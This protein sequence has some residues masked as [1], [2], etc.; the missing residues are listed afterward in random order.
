MFGPPLK[1]DV[2]G[3]RD[4]YL[5]SASRAEGHANF[6][7][8]DFLEPFDIMLADLV[9]RGELTAFGQ[10]LAR[11][12][13][14][15]AL[16]MRLK[17][18][19]GGAAANTLK[20]PVFI[21]GLPRT[22]TT[23]LHEL[24]S[25]HPDLRA[26]TFHESH[27]YPH[28]GW[29]DEPAKAITHVQLFCVDTLAPTF[30]RVHELKAHGPHECVSIQGYAFRSM[31]FHVAFRLPLYNQFM[32]SDFDWAPAYKL[33]NQYLS[34]LSNPGDR[35]IL[36]APG[37]ML[38]LQGL[39]E[40]YPD[41]LFIQTHRNPLEVIPSMASLTQSLRGMASRTINTREIGHDVNRL[42]HKGISNVLALRQSDTE[43]DK[44]FLDLDF[45][46][47]TSEP[48]AALPKIAA[49]LGL[50]MTEQYKQDLRSHLA[51]NRRHKHGVHK[52]SLEQFGLDAKDLDPMYEE[53]NRIYLERE[54]KTLS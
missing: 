2:E 49:F 10:L 46:E 35:W 15:H 18:Q 34:Q 20:R 12:F 47:L 33:H 24:L 7:S 21:L 37:H 42:W 19:K 54:P 45:S 11:Y 3:L 1:R 4:A 50:E 8:L 38:G 29:R 25:L 43:I 13:L 51:E 32:L 36:K 52:Y 17:I 53:Y 26:P 9:R 40:Q 48:A 5:E 27:H 39:I 16:R 22:G 31:H 6:G 14:K 30:K 28:D 44:R 41:A 23:I